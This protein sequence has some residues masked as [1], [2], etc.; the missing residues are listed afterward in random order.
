M[1]PAPPTPIWKLGRERG[2]QYYLA[3]TAGGMALVYFVLHHRGVSSL[4]ALLPL[5]VGIGGTA[6][7]WSRT[8]VVYLIALAVVVS[9]PPNRYFMTDRGGSVWL[10]DVLLCSGVLAFVAGQYRLY[11]LVRG[12][13]PPP[14]AETERVGDLPRSAPAEL[15]RDAASVAPGEVAMLVLLLPAWAVL[16]QFASVLLPRTLAN[17]G[18]KPDAWRAVMLLWL[19]AITALVIASAFDYYH[20]R[21]MTP[22]EATLYLQDVLWQE[23][24]R[25]QRRH[26]RWRAWARLGNPL[27]LVDRLI[28]LAVLLWLTGLTIVLVTATLWICVSIF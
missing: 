4:A 7:G 24:R 21:S 19:L 12:V 27:D 17:P 10:S 15:R 3:M 20:R 25:E 22:T 9:I 5:L 11:A 8:P 18:L 6:I 1:T 28:D 16:A 13:F 26:D 23:T 2:V 14:R